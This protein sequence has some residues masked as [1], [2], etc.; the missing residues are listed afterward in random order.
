LLQVLPAV[1]VTQVFGFD[2]RAVWWVLTCSG[3]II[4]VLFYIYYRRG[5][6]LTAKV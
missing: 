3:I 5:R 6:W 2:E 4:T 1:I